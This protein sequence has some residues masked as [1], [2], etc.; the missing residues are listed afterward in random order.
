MEVLSCLKNYKYHLF[1]VFNLLWV[2]ALLSPNIYYF[3]DNYRAAGGYYNWGGDFRPFADYLYY[4][5]GMGRDFTDL[6]PLPQLFALIFLYYTYLIYIKK[7]SSEKLSIPVLLV[8]LPIVWNPFLLSNLYFRYDSIF[9]LLAVLISVL[10]TFDVDNK[11]YFRAVILLFI[12]CGLYQPAIVAYVCTVLFLVYKI[13]VGNKNKIFIL[14]FKQSLIFFFIFLVS[15]SFYYFTIMKFT[16]DYNF[17]SATH[18]QMAINKLIP[19]IFQVVKEFLVIFQGDTGFIF[20]AIFSSLIIINFIFMVK[21]FSFLGVIVFIVIQL[22]FVCSAA[23]VNIFL[24]NPRFEY[25][26]FIF[27][28]FYLSYLL[29]SALFILNLNKYK[30]YNYAILFF[31]SFYFLSISLSLS[32]IQKSKKIFDNY[33]ILNIV[34]D[35]YSHN[36]DENKYFIFIGEINT[37]DV[38]RLIDKYPINKGIT[39]NSAYYTYK[40]QNYFPVQLKYRKFRSNEEK[41]EFFRKNKNDFSLVENEKFYN[42]YSSKSEVVVY[43]NSLKKN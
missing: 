22:G 7:F 26:T 30:K 43:F 16:T 17:Y 24:E 11:K 10:A 12:A 8:F 5:I 9:M 15:L 4:I 35:L 1:I 13:E 38:Y 3:D 40:M 39:S 41:Y 29:F 42:I 37:Y 6:T 27:F 14:W 18:G 20:L 31:V 19:N 34:N 23:G 21:K 2:W 25:R 36:L 28:G 32:S 33:L